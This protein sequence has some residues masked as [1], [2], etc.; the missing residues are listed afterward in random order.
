[1][2]WNH[3]PKGKAIAPLAY[4][5]LKRTLKK[6]DYALYVSQKFLQKRYPTNGLQIGIGDVR[7]TDHGDYILKTVSIK[8]QRPTCRNVSHYALSAQYT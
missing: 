1:M 5:S 2:L 7:I 4:F 3:S 6:S 8:F